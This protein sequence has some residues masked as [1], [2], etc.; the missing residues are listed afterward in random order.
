MDKKSKIL[1]WIVILSILISV[2]YTFYKTVILGDF[3]VVNISSEGEDEEGTADIS[4][5]TLDSIVS[6]STDAEI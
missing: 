5:T 1:L 3:E 4:T 6:T 2:G